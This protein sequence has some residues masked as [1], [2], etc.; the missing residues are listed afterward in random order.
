MLACIERCLYM[1]GTHNRTGVT[2]K[3]LILSE[4]DAAMMLDRDWFSTSPGFET[5]CW[6][7][8]YTTDFV[9]AVS[10][11]NIYYL[12]ELSSTSIWRL[13]QTSAL[14]PKYRCLSG[15]DKSLSVMTVSRIF[16]DS[17]TLQHD[18]HILKNPPVFTF[19]HPAAVFQSSALVDIAAQDDSIPY[20]MSIHTP[21]VYP[22]EEVLL[23]IPTVPM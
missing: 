2:G 13:L 15:R 19:P 6:P 12:Q 20:L 7:L 1:I 14:M 16:R 10:T 4:S 9:L 21:S 17:Y 5:H 23:A 11:V 8:H 18:H 22:L 3:L